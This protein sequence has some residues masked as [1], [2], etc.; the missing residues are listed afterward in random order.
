MIVDE[1]HGSCGQSERR[2]AVATLCRRA[3]FVLL[4]SA[5]PH[6]GDEEAFAA[7]CALGRLDDR[8]VVFRR[9]RLDVGR[10]AGRRVHTARV[11]LT[12]AERRMHAALATFT[13]AVRRERTD[14]NPHVWLLLSLLHKRALSSAHALAASAERRLRLL[15]QRPAERGAQLLLPLDD[16][17]GELDAA[18][19]APMWFAPALDDAGRE[20]RLLEQ[21]VDA[22]N[23]AAG[24]ESKLL[25]LRRLLHAIREPVIVF[26]EY[27]DTLHHVRAQVAP[28][29]AVLHG[30]MTRDQ[31][32]AALASF[33]QARVLLATDAAGEGLNLHEH[34]R[35]VVNLEL[36]WN[37]M[38]LEQR[39]G[40]V[41]RIG[42]Q[43]RVHAFHLVAHGTGETRLLDRL[44]TR[45]T[46]A[47]LRVG[48]SD[49]LVGRPEW[50][51]ERSA[52]LVVLR[53]S[54]VDAAPAPMQTP[55]L[56][57]TRMIDEAAADSG[58]IAMLRSLGTDDS[59]RSHRAATP[60]L[61]VDRPLSTHTR[62][63]A[64]RATLRGGTL[65]IYRSRL[66]DGAGRAIATHVSGV[67]IPHASAG[68]AAH[69]LSDD[70]TRLVEPSASTALLRSVEIHRRLTAVRLARARAIAALF[71]AESEEQ[72]PGL[73]DRREERRWSER[74]AE[75]LAALALAEDRLARV[76]AAGQVCVGNA[77]HLLTLRPSHVSGVE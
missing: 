67:L 6:N 41:D 43:R 68:S 77:E 44:A 31:R 38:R 17:E 66:L 56:E 65:Q 76:V 62:R 12:P 21:V 1:V 28:D 42:Q 9:S 39:I 71:K 50:T 15:E 20:R 60:A 55:A 70:I 18:D 5:T 69:G 74:R 36:P 52:R 22:A 23:R 75:R 48:A 27:R 35:I 24:S 53:D 25:R 2:D 26:T 63:H 45:V 51:E 54:Q 46:N 73:F 4:L 19:A 13:R 10:D 34:C 33:P 7:L 64:S 8:L 40:R 16:E 3:P 37:P 11:A 14:I 29:A 72:Q 59:E 57:A 30:G 47:R 49:P 32:H 61:A 58:R